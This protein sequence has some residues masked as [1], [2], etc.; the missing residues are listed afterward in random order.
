M[1]KSTKTFIIL[2][3]ISV[4]CLI[5][6]IHLAN[7]QPPVKKDTTVKKLQQKPKY[8]YFVKMRTEDVNQFF[9]VLTSYKNAVIYEPGHTPDQTISLQK[10]IDSYIENLKKSLKIDSAIIK[11]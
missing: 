10:G 7:A 11:K 9:Q 3:C 5:T 8:E 2:V 4:L 1:K 6:G